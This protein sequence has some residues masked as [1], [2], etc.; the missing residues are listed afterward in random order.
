MFL[1]VVV[2]VYQFEFEVELSQSLDNSP[3]EYPRVGFC[4]FIKHPY[5]LCGGLCPLSQFQLVPIFT[6]LS[7]LAVFCSIG[8]QERGDVT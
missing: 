8:V 5:V 2:W 4:N 7:E 6:T 3:V 1:H